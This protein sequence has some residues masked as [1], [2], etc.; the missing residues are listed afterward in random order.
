MF[1][2][3][4]LS[5]HRVE[6]QPLLSCLHNAAPLQLGADHAVDAVTHGAHEASHGAGQG[7]LW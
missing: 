3:K 2:R 4:A 6:A 1:C 7:G 5:A